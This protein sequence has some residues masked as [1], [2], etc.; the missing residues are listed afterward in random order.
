MPPCRTPKTRPVAKSESA[1]S[2]AAIA[3]AARARARAAVLAEQT[4]RQEA[5]SRQHAQALQDGDDDDGDD[6]DDDDDDDEEEEEEED[7]SDMEEDDDYIEEGEG[8]GAPVA[9]TPQ[10]QRGPVDPL[11]PGGVAAGVAEDDDYALTPY[12]AHKGYLKLN[13]SMGKKLYDQA[14]EPLPHTFNG[15]TGELLLLLGNSRIRSQECGWGNILNVPILS[16]IHI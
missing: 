14:C 7:L 1:T 3:A 10:A 12:L 16:L 15:A 8:P 5:V 11:G 6:D 13:T 9:A 2:R 4:A